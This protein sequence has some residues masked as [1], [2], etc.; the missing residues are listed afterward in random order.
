ML[1]PNLQVHNVFRQ[2]DQVV[3]YAKSLEYIQDPE[4]RWPG[5]RSKFVHVL[6]YDLFN[7][8]CKRTLA[9]LYPMNY[10][11]MRFKA[12]SQFQTIPAAHA[13]GE[14]WIHQDIYSQIT[15]IIYLSHHD[16]CGT[17]LYIPENEVMRPTFEKNNSESFD[18]NK[19]KETH[20]L[21]NKPF[22]DTY[23]K[24]LKINNSNYIKTT[25]FNS[26]YN[27]MVVF[28]GHTH[29]NANG[30]VD[31]NCPGDRL[32]LVTFFDDITSSETLKYSGSELLK[33]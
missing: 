16:N 33:I 2:P 3:E 15:C 4:G 29:H 11:H 32:T 24:A 25:S 12:H 13:G 27:S 10:H 26:I 22:D 20:Y 19:I 1:Y 23:Y 18:V 7:M 21:Q 6:N 17:N 30:F 9:V 28:D 31:S 14:G 8:V 5:K